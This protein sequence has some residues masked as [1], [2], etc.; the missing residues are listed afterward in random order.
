[1]TN[2]RDFIKQSSIMAMGA[3][4]ANPLSDLSFFAKQKA[5][6]LQLFTLFNVLDA[7]VK[8][9]LQKV[10]N[11]GFKEVESAFSKLGGYY[12]M[13]PKEF[14]A[15]LGDLGLK[16]ASHHAM[17]APFKPRPGFDVSKM[18][19]M[20]NL[21]DNAQQIID[22]ASEGGVKFLVCASIPIETLDEVKQAVEILG[23]AGETAKKAGLTFVYHNHDREFKDVEGQQPYTMFLSQIKPEIMKMELDLAWVSKAGV[24]PVELF[25]KHPKRFPL[26]HVKD[27]DK[28]FKTLMPVGE[29]V[30]DFKRIFMHAKDAG[31]KHFFVEHDMPAD[32][33]KSISSSISNLKKFI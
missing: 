21:R 28:E 32:A 16:W 8:G 19:K 20:L 30:I 25:T 18:P 12:G 24:D 7:D 10:A 17:G 22:E 31:M 13:K 2:R 9:N 1:M 3:L 14:K 23:K 33:F 5:V 26:W 6:G 11:L 27:F 15:L 29:G 4:A